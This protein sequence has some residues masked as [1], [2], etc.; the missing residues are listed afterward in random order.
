MIVVTDGGRILG[1]GDLGANG[2][3]IPIGKLSLYTACAGV[4]PE[5]CLPVTLDVGT[6]NE[7]LRNDPS[8]LGE[9]HARTDGRSRTT[10]C[11]TSSSPPRSP[12]FPGVVVQFEDFNNACAF[13]P[14]GDAIARGSA[15]S[16]TMCR[17]L[18]RWG[19]PGCTRPVASPERAS[20][21][22][23]SCS[24]GAGEACLG[25]GAI[26]VAAMQR[27][28]L[29]EAEARQRCLFI[30]SSGRG[31]REPARSPRAQAAVRPGADARAG[32]AGRGGGLQADGR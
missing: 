20:S 19:W 12:C 21:S 18:A 11:S 9:R 4:P 3:G 13:R 7:S 16:T 27:E 29:S 5:L 15:A 8:Y 6:D 1:L 24:S 26:V 30:D 14:A 22:N 23:G 28:G 10:R 32:S 17:A 31:G 25:I 2:M